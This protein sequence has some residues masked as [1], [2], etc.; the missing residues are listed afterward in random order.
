[1]N[2]PT[3]VEQTQKDYEFAR[4]W[5]MRLSPSEITEME[6]LTAASNAL[7]LSANW[8]K[9]PVNMSLKDLYKEWASKNLETIN[10]IIKFMVNIGDYS[11]YFTDIDETKQWFTG[12][13]MIL[14]DFI[15]IFRKEDR[16]I[17]I[18]FTI[19]IV[20]LMV[21]YIQIIDNK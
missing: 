8:Y 9:N 5:D 12:I 4:N 6:R 13:Y 21:W 19:M 20:A 3:N 11:K 14:K 18:G 10:D 1:M 2:R 7:Q 17:Y 16:S 15:D